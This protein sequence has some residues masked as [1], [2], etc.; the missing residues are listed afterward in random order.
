MVDIFPLQQVTERFKKQEFI[1]DIS[2]T[3]D[4]TTY[5]N[6]AKLQVSQAKCDVLSQFNVG[7]TVVVSFNV[8]GNRWEKDGKTNYINSLDV[9]RIEIVLHGETSNTGKGYSQGGEDVPF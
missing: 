7:D 1:L 5:E 2:E 9:W 8:R 3:K 4:G 6:Y